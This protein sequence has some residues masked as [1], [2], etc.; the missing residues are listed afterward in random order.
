MNIIHPLVATFIVSLI[1]LVGLFFFSLRR[2]LTHKIILG[3]VAFAAGTMLAT[4][5]LHLLPEALSQATSQ[6]VLLWV[7]GG[8][9]LF[10]LVEKI[11]HWRHCH[12][13][14]GDC[15]IHAFA[16]LN[17][18]GD[19]L[20]NFIDGLLIAA[21]FVADIHLGYVTTLAVLAHELPQE[22]G[23]FG[24]LLHAGFSRAKALAFNFL[25]ALTAVAGAVVGY[26]LAQTAAWLPILL[27][28]TA[29]GFLYVAAVDL[30]PELRQHG[31]GWK[32]VILTSVLFLAGIGLMAVFKD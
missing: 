8:F 5:L 22:I 14:D 24:V 7:L 29:G 32:K 3:L 19:G 21:S 16:Y 2:T 26:F 27:A 1:S 23:D 31:R 15:R 25:T 12:E 20:H 13:A 17:L 4:A 28:L 6:E 9:I 10:F 11:F 18:F 30:L